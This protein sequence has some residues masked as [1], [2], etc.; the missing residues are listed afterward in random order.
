MDRSAV[1][2]HPAAIVDLLDFADV[3]KAYEGITGIMRA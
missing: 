3:T 2:A 1:V